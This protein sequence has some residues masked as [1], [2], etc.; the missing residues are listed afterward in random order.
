MASTAVPSKLF[1]ILMTSTA[2]L[3]GFIF[4]Y[5]Y[6]VFLFASFPREKK[7]Y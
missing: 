7:N 1:T 5:E 4:G 2:S 3:G 6:V